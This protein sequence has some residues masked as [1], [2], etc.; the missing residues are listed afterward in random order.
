MEIFF[1]KLTLSFQLLIPKKK[2]A[3]ATSAKGK[4]KRIRKDLKL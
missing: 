2:S 1:F 4:D 3:E